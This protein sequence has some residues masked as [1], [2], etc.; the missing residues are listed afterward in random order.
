MENKTTA[1][2]IRRTATNRIRR[3][4]PN[5]AREIIDDMLAITR[6]NDSARS[7]LKRIVTRSFTGGYWSQSLDGHV[8]RELGL[9]AMQN[10]NN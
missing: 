5:C 7:T 1:Q 4:N 6:A 8:H 9:R 3:L 2:T 10:N